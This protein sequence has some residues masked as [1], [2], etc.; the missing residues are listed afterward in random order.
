MFDC[1]LSAVL[2]LLSS[3]ADI[4]WLAVLYYSSLLFFVLFACALEV[5]KSSFKSLCNNY[6][7]IILY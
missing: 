5:F 3:S 4:D 2:I 1:S 6:Y 7:L